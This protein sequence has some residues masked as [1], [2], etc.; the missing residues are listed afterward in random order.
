MADD[1][2]SRYVDILLG[3]VRDCRYP[4]PTMMQRVERAVPDRDAAREYLAAVMDIVAAERFPSPRLLDHMGEIL[5]AL[6]GR[7]VGPG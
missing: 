2:R 5:D 3:Q 1:M 4:S 7:V 6:D